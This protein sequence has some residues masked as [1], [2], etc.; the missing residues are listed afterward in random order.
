[1]KSKFSIIIGMET[2]KIIRWTRT[3]IHCLISH[4]L[5]LFQLYIFTIK[6]IFS[7]Q[8]LIIY[9]CLICPCRELFDTALYGCLPYERPVGTCKMPEGVCIESG[10]VMATVCEGATINE[11]CFC[12]SDAHQSPSPSPSPPFSSPISAPFMAISPH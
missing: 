12:P 3:L 7:I 1:M 8:F 4:P 2:E 9:H 11:T 10:N 5:Y 6:T